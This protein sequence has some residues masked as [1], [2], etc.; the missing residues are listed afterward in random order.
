MD[1]ATKCGDHTT[2][3]THWM[4]V[5]LET[6]VEIKNFLMDEH[7]VF[8]AVVELKKLLSRWLVTIEEDET[9]LNIGTVLH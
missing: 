7:L 1:K 2:H 3:D 6:L 5:V 8:D 4:G 9:N